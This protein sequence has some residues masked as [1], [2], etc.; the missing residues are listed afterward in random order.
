VAGGANEGRQVRGALTRLRFGP[1]QRWLRWVIRL[2]FVAALVLTIR[3]LKAP[4]LFAAASFWMVADRPLEK[5][6]A[7]VVL[8]GGA[9]NRP[10]E[11]ARLYHRGMAPLILV[12]DVRWRP[13]D[14][15]ELTIPES[16]MIRKILSRLGVPDVAVV[17]IGDKVTNTHDEALAVTEWTR[18]TGA[19][20]VIV[21]TE[22]F[23]TRRVKW[24]FGRMLRPLGARVQTDA[25]NSIEYNE[26]NW[27]QEDGGVVSFQNEVIK[28]V[29]YFLKY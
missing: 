20:S 18:R 23:H 3:A 29:Y 14:Q 19:K 13:T 24:F 21:P 11:A 2:T 4:I 17:A 6:D 22:L 12:P 16:R 5:A 15:M 26:A 7:I 1:S 10:F 25:V 28:F 9:Q 27:W 8:G